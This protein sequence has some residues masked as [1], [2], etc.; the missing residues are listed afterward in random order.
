MRCISILTETSSSCTRVRRQARDSCV[1]SITRRV[2]SPKD[3]RGARA[4]GTSRTALILAS[5]L[6][7]L[8]CRRGSRRGAM[9]SNGSTRTTGGMRVRP[10]VVP[11]SCVRR[12]LRW[13]TGPGPIVCH[14]RFRA[15]S[16]CSLRV[17]A[18]LR[19]LLHL[20]PHR[21]R[22]RR[23]RRHRRCRRSRQV[24]VWSSA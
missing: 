4:A 12:S 24:I 8:L 7:T 11:V 3:V 18:C 10:W 1:R 13:P 21:R 6:F 2:S 22:H 15:A 17:Q 14:G 5:S 9:P 19:C 20:L 23:H 16:A